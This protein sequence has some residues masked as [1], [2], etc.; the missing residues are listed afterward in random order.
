MNSGCHFCGTDDSALLWVE[1][2]E[3]GG[4]WVCPDCWRTVYDKNL[5]VSG[6]GSSK[7]SSGSPCDT[8]ACS[9]SR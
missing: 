5:F 2:K 4:M 7:G 6:S 9:C 1:H 8:C 3:L